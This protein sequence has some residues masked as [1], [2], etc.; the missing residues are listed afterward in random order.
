MSR[1][2]DR[3]SLET[4]SGLHIWKLQMLVKVLRGNIKTVVKQ[5]LG[6][7][8]KIL[9]FFFFNQKEFQ[10]PSSAVPQAIWQGCYVDQIFAWL[11]LFHK[12]CLNATFSEK[13]PLIISSIIAYL[14]SRTLN[15]LFCL[16]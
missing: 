2:V 15:T 1:N 7:K 11:N 12:L 4:N 3:T 9:G 6:R 16:F 13:T 5:E 14:Q 8:G 10:R